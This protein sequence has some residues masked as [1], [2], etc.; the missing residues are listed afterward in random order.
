MNDFIR[1]FATTA[2]VVCNDEG[3]A[4]AIE[5]DV[6]ERYEE[7][8]LLQA[9]FGNENWFVLSDTTNG[10]EHLQEFIKYVDNLIIDVGGVSEKTA[11]F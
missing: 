10:Y 9:S 1:D 11:V 7:A 2:L 5:E 3:I 4:N 6:F 8:E